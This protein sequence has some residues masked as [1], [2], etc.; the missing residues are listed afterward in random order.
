MNPLI[1]FY[2]RL[3]RKNAKLSCFQPLKCGDLLLCSVS[4]EYKQ[5]QYLDLKF[6]ALF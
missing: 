4:Y 5:M 6:W 3:T 2:E 1:V